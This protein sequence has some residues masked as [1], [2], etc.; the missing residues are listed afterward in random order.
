MGYT[1]DANGKWTH[2]SSSKSG[3]SKNGGSSKKSSKK[4]TSS[5]GNTADTK[6]GITISDSNA[7]DSKAYAEECSFTVLGDYTIKMGTTLKVRKGVA[8]RWTGNW[9]ITE[10]THT[11]DSKGY[12][13]EGKAGR[14]PYS[15]STSSGSTKSKN[16]SKS[17]SK[18][19][20]NSK[21]TTSKS[22]KKNNTKNPK[23][24]TSSSTKWKMDA[25]GK[26]KKVSK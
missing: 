26:W 2:K 12:L 20:K 16:G 10:T 19:S 6:K 23:K 3:S 15:T 17:S 11:I 8:S 4:T 22:P 13:I 14:I 25:N 7:T 18:S 9:K 24:K 5:K 1:M 21:K